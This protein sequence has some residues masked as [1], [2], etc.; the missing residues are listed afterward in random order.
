MGELRNR[1]SRDLEIRGY[2]EKT[3]EAYLYHLKLFTKYYMKAPNQLGVQDVYRYQQHLIRDRKVSY[4]Y[5]NQ[6]VQ[7]IRFFYGKTLSVSWDINML[8]FHKQHRSVPVVLS[9]EEVTA[10]LDAPKFPKHRRS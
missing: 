7:A 4:S 9:V 2:S 8:P 1:M 5:F 10:L 6:A 3:R